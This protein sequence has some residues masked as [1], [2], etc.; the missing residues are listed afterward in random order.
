MATNTWLVYRTKILK[1]KGA[2][3]NAVHQIL[4]GETGS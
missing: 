3:A 1:E 2:A 4:D